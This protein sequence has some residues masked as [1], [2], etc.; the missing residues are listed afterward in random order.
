MALAVR[1]K[2]GADVGLAMTPLVSEESEESGPVGTTH[3]G[4]AMDDE[5]FV[6]SGYYPT[7]RLRIRA[8]AVTHALLELAKCVETGSGGHESR[9]G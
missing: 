2:L 3:I 6:R 1:E 7:R 4:I 5:V 9:W 8:R